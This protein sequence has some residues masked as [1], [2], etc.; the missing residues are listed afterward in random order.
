MDLLQQLLRGHPGGQFL[1]GL[2]G[3][4]QGHRPAGE[5]PEPHHRCG[6]LRPRRPF[7]ELLHRRGP[8]GPRLLLCR[9]DQDVRWRSDRGEDPAA[10]RRRLRGA[11]LLRSLR[12]VH[13][14]RDRQLEG[15]ARPELE[16]RQHPRGPLHPGRR[17]GHQ[18]PRP[19]VRRLPAAQ[20]R[21]GPRQ[22]GPRR[23]GREGHPRESGPRLHA[24]RGLR[25]L[26]PGKQLAFQQGDHLCGPPRGEQHDGDEQLPDR[27]FRWQER[28]VPD[29]EPGFRL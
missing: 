3:G 25:Q 26:F 22:V 27:H 20:S 24:G 10:E 28:R 4:R 12:R 2:R 23:R 5:E 8:C 18:G 6:E 9:A 11:F 15:S 17:P 1:P 19:A 14:Q 13:R 16:R 21:R 7:P 29:R